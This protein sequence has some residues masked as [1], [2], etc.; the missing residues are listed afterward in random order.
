MLK[1]PEKT[2]PAELKTLANRL[3]TEYEL[4]KDK[5]PNQQN[6][7]MI[8]KFMLIKSELKKRGQVLLKKQT[9]LDLDSAALVEI[10]K[11]KPIPF[12]PTEHRFEDKDTKDYAP[13][14][15]SGAKDGDAIKLDQVEPY[16]K[17]FV[18]ANPMTW[19][20]GGVITHKDDGTQGDVDVLI[21]APSREELEKVISFRIWRMIP[22]KLRKR[23][24]LLCEERGGLSPFTDFLSLYRLVMER[25]PD[26][27]IV[28]MEEL[29]FDIEAEIVLRTKGTK[30]QAEEAS[31]AAKEDK[32]TFNEFFLPQKPTRGYVP[33]QTQT[34]EFFISLWK[35]EQFPVYSSRKADGINT[36]WHISKDGKVKVYTEDGTD[37]TSSFPETIKEAAKLAPG[38]DIILLAEAE[39]WKGKQHF[40]R[41]VAAGKTHK[42]HP[43]ET[44]IIINVYDMVYYDEDIHKKPYEERW[45]LLQ[46]L[47]FPQK[48]ET[49]STD[50]NWN[51]IPHI[52]NKNRE[53]LE[54][55]TK[56][57][58]AIIGSEGNVA[59]QASA[60]HDLTGRRKMSWI[61]YHNSSQFTT[62]ILNPIETKT[63]GIYNL[64]YAILAGDRSIQEKV[65]RMID[66]KKAVYVGKS[67]ATKEKVLRGESVI[68]EAET[69][70]II[71][72]MKKKAYDVTFWA[73]R[74]LG[75]TDKKPQ[76]IDEVED[77]AI[78]DRVFQA[79]LVDESGKI[80]YLP[81]A[82][83]EEISSKSE[84]WS[85]KKFWTGVYEGENPEWI[86][87]KPSNLTRYAISKYKPLGRV[88][89][90]GSAAGIDSFLLA[91]VADSV[92]GIDI[93]DEAV[94][95]AKKN[96]K[97][98]PKSIQDK[99]RF[100]V[101]DAEKL[102]FDDD[103]F[104]FVFSLS[105][106]H[107]TDI[108]KSLAEINRVLSP[109]GNVVIYAYVK[110]E[111]KIS[112]KKFIDESEKYFTILDKSLKD[113]TDS[114]GAK[115]TALI[116]ELESKK[117][118]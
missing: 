51:L 32:I 116:I 27:E 103:S 89:E 22:E 108:I 80:H 57:L 40:P 3:R 110:G 95:Q 88:L 36:E 52:K 111:R 29:D 59:K 28:K 64:E 30:K 92:V 13:V 53:E 60:G 118:E 45:D 9:D 17:S 87:K 7:E 56:R 26:A 81:G 34:L 94:A 35:D 5:H 72:D 75:K 97:D 16:F 105:V 43:D 73:P 101:G 55:E 44:G 68:I 117:E 54:K 90:I 62:I 23:L 77:Q 8:N 114:T 50:H 58:R 19:L 39:W 86:K 65:T 93:V 104:D 31:K 70:N 37:E 4:W 1:N 42:I 14:D 91:T 102:E 38:H 25:I 6:E 113:T 33:G 74:Y 71:Y 10:T 2:N 98:Q 115:R 69:V 76:T 20:V 67:F 47:N 46:K 109:K 21:T 85:D 15:T 49:P 79:K 41:E 82:S 11:I 112:E 96:F 84:I 100:E 66:G 83:G 99:V 24:H 61:K 107:D 78:K 12:V 18:V 106:L 48:S 63:K